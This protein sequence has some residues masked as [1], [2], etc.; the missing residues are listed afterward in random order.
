MNIKKGDHNMNSMKKSLLVLLTFASCTSLFSWHGGR[1]GGRGY[2]GRGYGWG[3]DG[4]V[5]AGIIGGTALGLAAASGGSND[6]PE[7][8]DANRRR[9]A[10]QKQIKD[11][12][13]EKAK[14]QKAYDKTGDEDHL[15]II[16][17]LEKDIRRLE[18]QLATI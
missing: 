8:L 16:Q 13:R 6:T 10:V 17:Q 15:S 7:T 1:W 5:A 18:D 14:H 12:N 9:K 4:A 3:G 2:Y 11:K